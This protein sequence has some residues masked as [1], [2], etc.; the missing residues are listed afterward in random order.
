MIPKTVE[1]QVQIVMDSKGDSLSADYHKLDKKIA[2]LNMVA[3]AA[4]IILIV[5]MSTKPF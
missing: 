2:K 4:A 1:K 5:L 3:H